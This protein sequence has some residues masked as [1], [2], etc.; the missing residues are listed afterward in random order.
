MLQDGAGDV[1][2]TLLV[3]RLQWL[4]GWA[5]L[6]AG[7]DVDEHC[8]LLASG[9]IS[10]HAELA[11]GAMAALELLPAPPPPELASSGGRRSGRSNGGID[12]RLPSLRER[13][14]LQ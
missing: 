1:Q 9:C 5:Q 8:R 3:E 13:L 11:R 6:E 4:L 7:Q 10:W 2:E 12:V 14:V